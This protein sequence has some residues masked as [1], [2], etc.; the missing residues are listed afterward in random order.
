MKRLFVTIACLSIFASLH[1][2]GITLLYKNN[3]GWNDSL[4]WIQINPPAGQMPI[5]RVPTENDDV[6]FSFSMSGISSVGFETD[7]ANPGFNVGGSSPNG[8][9]RCRSMH[10]SNTNISFYPVNFIDYGA[11]VN[12]YTSNGG[13]VILDSNTNLDKGIFEL[14]GGNPAIAD[15]QIINS[16]FGILT[17]FTDFADIYMDA[18]SKARLVGSTYGG[19]SFGGGS[20]YAENSTINTDEFRLGDNSTDTILNST[21]EDVGLC[22]CLTFLIGKN[23]N[24]VSSNVT[25]KSN[26][27]LSFGTSGS[28]LNGN[29]SSLSYG[30]GYFSFLQE[31]PANP[32]PNIINGNLTVSENEALGFNGDVKISG[33]IIFHVIDQFYDGPSFVAPVVINGQH[34]FDVGG[35]I[36]YG[37]NNL[38]ITGCANNYC[39][40]KLEFFGNTNSNIS[41]PGGFPVDTLIINKTGC[42]KV[43]IDSS[44]YVS[45]A[46]RIERGQLVLNPND[47]IPYKFVCAGNLDIA[48]GG[49]LFLRKDANGVVANMA[50]G[51]TLVDHNSVKDST[52]AGLSNPYNGI[53]TTP[54]NQQITLLYHKDKGWNDSLSWIQINPP[55]G[56]APIQRV[57]TENDDVVISYAMS[58]I[59]A[60]NFET[61][62][63]NPDFNV[64]GSSPNGPSR[65]RSMHISNT[66]ISIDNPA[67][68]DGAPTV[69]IYT[70]NG[71]FVKID[72]GSNML[73]GH[74]QLHGGNKAITDLEILNSTYG[75][76]FSHADW[77]GIKWDADARIKLVGSNLGGFAFFGDS[78]GNIFI[79]GCTIETTNFHL[80]DHSTA[81]LLNSTVTNNGNNVSMVF[82]IGKN[83]TFVS[84]KDTVRSYGPLAFTTSGS[85]LNG[86]VS[87]CSIPAVLDFLQE[88]PANPLPN[89]INGNLSAAELNTTMGISGDLK[90]SGNISGFSDYAVGSSTP[91]L[92]N[93]QE[94]FDMGGV[95]NYG[96]TT[97]ISNCA[98][99]FCHFKLEL[100]GNTNS[101]ITWNTGFP[102]DTLIINKTG[103]AKVTIDSSLYVSG[104]TRI[105]SGQLVL[106][107]NDN[108]P[109]K[110]VCAGNVDI[111]QGGGLFLRK[112]ANGVVANMAVKGTLV[113][114]NASADSTCAGLSNPYNGIISAGTSALPDSLFN[115][116][117]S[118]QNKTVILSWSTIGEINT[119]YFT[120]EKSFDQAT[121]LPVGNITASGNPGESDYQFTDHLSLKAMNYY[122]LKIVNADSLF[123]YSKII[124]VA[125]PVSDKIIIFP[126]PAKDKITIRLV[127]VSATTDIVIADERG[128]IVKKL[129]LAAGILETSVNIADLQPGVYSIS[130][131]SGQTKSIQQFVKL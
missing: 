115:F 114:H 86:N 29:V 117:G 44:L 102:V 74:F 75:V 57:P 128:M 118:Y 47:S 84:A 2:Q 72:S 26:S 66:T 1:A 123:T 25:V 46:T 130:F 97:A 18:N 27:N 58:G 88:D 38:T 101:R 105:E 106:N 109:Y 3:R 62:N 90:I 121:F 91:V 9:S 31:D 36:N 80:G 40:Y 41:W 71:G 52:C 67:I 5:Q 99:N 129:Q 116:I 14:H 60:V 65:C 4:S 6:V 54:L 37:G 15:L 68:V 76:L 50:F 34:A 81:T 70:S 87:A 113:D 112:D 98:N 125:A 21:I 33:D 127:N 103:C 93:G 13:F 63:I 108:H 124:A 64:G 48:Q 131:Q 22:G 107:P 12:V 45:G 11:I 16:N 89:I 100:F 85:Q 49:G 35:V 32:L 30:G 10:V 19:M 42:A 119:K 51:G 94:V 73:H 111:A 96:G 92:V 104:A 23:A 122:R 78:S 39:H 83:S 8:P 24:F 28:I 82:F 20:L 110:F 95:T 61:N 53:I 69:N 59:A 77:T 126:N 120:I 17:D 7:A 55:A 56:Q 43:T 79:D